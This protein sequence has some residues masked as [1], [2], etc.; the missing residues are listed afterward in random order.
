MDQSFKKWSAIAIVVTTQ[1]LWRDY[2]NRSPFSA[3]LKIVVRPQFKD[4]KLRGIGIRM[5]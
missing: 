2:N 4:E 1:G 3:I 5:S